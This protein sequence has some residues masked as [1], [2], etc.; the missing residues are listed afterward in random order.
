MIFFRITPQV[1]VELIT[2]KLDIQPNHV[3][4][5]PEQ[6]DLHALEVSFA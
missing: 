5:N 4:I 3:L 6:L 1:P 2:K